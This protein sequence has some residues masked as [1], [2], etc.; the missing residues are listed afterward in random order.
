M[1]FL[2]PPRDG[3]LGVQL[4]SEKSQQQ[5]IASTLIRK[6]HVEAVVGQRN[7]NDPA[8][9]FS[10]TKQKFRLKAIPKQEKK[11]KKSQK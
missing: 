7:D 4:L 2:L 5:R 9:S 1:F 8:T 10:P 6:S 11:N 3:W